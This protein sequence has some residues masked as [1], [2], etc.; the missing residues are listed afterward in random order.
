MAG[1]YDKCPSCGGID[2]KNEAGC[3]TCMECFW[4]ACTSG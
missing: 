4:S 3:S 2:M 1:V